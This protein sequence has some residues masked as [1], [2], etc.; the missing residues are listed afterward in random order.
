MAP[1]PATLSKW[2]NGDLKDGGV[3]E[4]GLSSHG[5]KEN[6]GVCPGQEGPRQ[7]EY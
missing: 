1:S 6:T 2:M 3:P 5:N 7:T 4:R